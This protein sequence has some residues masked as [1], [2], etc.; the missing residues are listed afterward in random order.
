MTNRILKSAILKSAMAISFGIIASVSLSSGTTYAADD[1]LSGPKDTTP[2]G[3]HWYYH[4]E[5]GTGRK[6]WY[7]GS[8][9]AKINSA[10]VARTTGTKDSDAAAATEEP[11]QPSVANA[12]AELQPAAPATAPAMTKPPAAIVAPNLF[13]SEVSTRDAAPSQ[14][15]STQT[16]ASRWPDPDAFR[17][18]GA[19]PQTVAQNTPAA[20]VSD[21]PSSVSDN[22]PASPQPQLAS[23]QPTPALAATP[24]SDPSSS[25]DVPVKSAAT[26]DTPDDRIILVALFVV[27]A[28]AA[29]LARAAFRYFGSHKKKER[30]RR[31]IWS[32]TE[33]GDQPFPPYA[34][35]ITPE[36]RVRNLTA[37][38]ED[39][40]EIEYLLRR[41]AR[42]E[43]RDRYFSS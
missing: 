9:G 22:P 20:S 24:Q 21:N 36:R 41:A 2:Q 16:L 12:R 30:P 7:L 23:P 3:S 31:D 29:V 17:P 13:S 1:C 6:C 25:H 43:A 10:P 42:R 26:A 33:H 28:I 5:R 19:Q 37:P 35:M 4:L 38:K 15:S 40:D 34:Q 18:S 32:Q 8:Q 11:M 27:L 39:A 14:G